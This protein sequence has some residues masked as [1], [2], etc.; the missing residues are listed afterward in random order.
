MEAISGM[1][2]YSSTETKDGYFV[3]FDKNG[4]AV[5]VCLPSALGNHTRDEERY[6]GIAKC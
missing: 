1:S 2:T 6:D 3:S 5:G 4:W